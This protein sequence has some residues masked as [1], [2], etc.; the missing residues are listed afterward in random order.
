MIES[1][2]GELEDTTDYESIM[3]E[4]GPTALFLRT[5][6]ARKVLVLAASRAAKEEEERTADMARSVTK[7]LEKHLL[8]QAS[9][10]G[11]FRILPCLP[12][13]Q[14]GQRDMQLVI[15]RRS[16]LGISF[17]D[18][19]GD[20][21]EKVVEFSTTESLKKITEQLKQLERCPITISELR[22]K[23]VVFDRDLEHLLKNQ[24]ENFKNY[25]ISTRATF[26][27]NFDDRSI[28]KRGLIKDS[29]RLKSIVTLI[30]L[31][32]DREHLNRLCK[33]DYHRLNR[34]L[35]IALLGKYDDIYLKT[36][37]DRDW[38]L[39]S[40]NTAYVTFSQVYSSMFFLAD[41]FVNTIEEN[42]YAAFLDDLA[43]RMIILDLTTNRVRFRHDETIL[44]RK[45][46]S[47]VKELHSSWRAFPETSSV[48]LTWE[49]YG[50]SVQSGSN[51]A[52][53]RVK[54]HK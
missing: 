22:C 49:L 43:Q 52:K 29:E 9:M 31:A 14:S 17:Q 4:L 44:S 42:N 13:L 18:L 12:S 27:H 6:T 35:Q 5:T 30:W 50:E 16:I 8:Q 2:A 48:K 34:K 36:L 3:D 51:R 23:R 33:S 47:F 40:D 1:K 38:E 15:H 28:L 25:S 7:R 39:D 24:T 20:N 37:T 19:V 46:F 21:D 53:I 32:A 11:E 45:L 54:F 10:T 41:M 26:D